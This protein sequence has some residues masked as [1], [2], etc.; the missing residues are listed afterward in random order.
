VAHPQ[1][2][3]THSV[4]DS[5]FREYI[6]VSQKTYAFLFSF[7]LYGR[8]IR[9]DGTNVGR[10][11]L[12]IQLRTPYVGDQGERTAAGLACCCLLVVV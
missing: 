4:T 7:L 2:L 9:R 1:Y 12:S 11:G 3:N 8:D 5:P 6:S 10:V